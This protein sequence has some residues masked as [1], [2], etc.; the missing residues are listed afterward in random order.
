LS[1]TVLMDESGVLAR[2]WGVRG[3]PATFIIDSEG[4]VDYAGQGYSTELGLR[5]RLWLAG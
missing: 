2:R 4:R 5:L 3:V 1:F